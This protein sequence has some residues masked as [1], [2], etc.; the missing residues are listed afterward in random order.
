MAAMIPVN[1]S[2]SRTGTQSACLAAC[3]AFA[4]AVKA[5]ADNPQVYE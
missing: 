5:V 4:E 2:Y 3:A 1:G